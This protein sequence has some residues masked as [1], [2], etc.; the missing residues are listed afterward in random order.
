MLFFDSLGVGGAGGDGCKYVAHDERRKYKWSLV[1][2]FGISS[3]TPEGN[4][5]ASSSSR[6][7]NKSKQP[8]EKPSQAAIG[9]QV[10]S[11]E[12]PSEGSTAKPPMGPGSALPP[13]PAG[14]PSAANKKKKAT[15]L[16]HLA[17]DNTLWR[18]ALTED[19]SS[20]IIVRN[21]AT[22]IASSLHIV[23][24]HNEPWI[25]TIE[26]R[27]TFVYSPPDP[28]A[29]PDKPTFRVGAL[30]YLDWFNTPCEVKI[31]EESIPAV[32]KLSNGGHGG[33]G[34]RGG[35][36]GIGANGAN[37]GEIS[38]A[39][40]NP[41]LMLN[42]HAE[43]LGGNGGFPGVAGPGGKGGAGGKGQVVGM[44]GP[45][46]VSGPEAPPGVAGKR[47]N[48]TFIRLDANGK[49][50]Q[51]GPKKPELKL[52]SMEVKCMSGSALLET[53]ERALMTLKFT[54]IG[55]ISCPPK[56]LVAISN[57]TNLTCETGFLIDEWL[58]PKAEYTVRLNVTLGPAPG[59][60]S[61]DLTCSVLGG[62]LYRASHELKEL[63]H[64]VEI[65]TI[66]NSPHVVF[67]QE[68]ELGAIIQNS[69]GIAT[70]EIHGR[71]IRCEI[72]LE[73]GLSF[74]DGA[75][76]TSTMSPDGLSVVE[77]VEDMREAPERVIRRVKFS[78]ELPPFS[79]K[80][81]TFRLYWRDDK[82]GEVTGKVK[83]I[84][85]Y[86]AEAATDAD[87]LVITHP[88][89]SSK[90][91]ARL[92]AMFDEYKLRVVTWDYYYYK[93]MKLPN[94][95]RAKLMLFCLRDAADIELLATDQIR[96]HFYGDDGSDQD[97]SLLILS[98][99][100]SET[101][102]LLNRRLVEVG[103]DATDEEMTKKFFSKPTTK[104]FNEVVHGLEK[105]YFPTF[106][107]YFVWSTSKEAPTKVTSGVRSKW[108]LGEVKILRSTLTY[109]HRLYIMDCDWITADTIAAKESEIL[110]VAI[111]HSLPISHKIFLIETDQRQNSAAITE[112]ALYYDLKSEFF[113]LPRPLTFLKQ[114]TDLLFQFTYR[115]ATER[116]VEAVMRCLYRL[117]AATYWKS[118]GFSDFK[119][120]Y[121][122]LESIIKRLKETLSSFSFEL[123]TNAAV[124]AKGGRRLDF[125][126]IDQKAQ[127]G[128]KSSSRVKWRKQ[129]LP[130]RLREIPEKEDLKVAP[131]ADISDIGLPP[132]NFNPSFLDAT[133]ATLTA[134]NIQ[135]QPPI[136]TPSSGS[137]S[138]S[139][140]TAAV[141]RSA[142]IS[143]GGSPLSTS[144]SG[145]ASAG[146]TVASTGRMAQEPLPYPDLHPEEND[147]LSG[148]PFDEPA[149]PPLP[150]NT[151]NL[152]PPPTGSAAFPSSSGLGIT[153]DM[154]ADYPQ[155]LPPLP[156]SPGPQASAE[157]QA[158]PSYY[159]EPAQP[160][161][162]DP[163]Q[164]LQTQVPPSATYNEETM[165]EKMNRLNNLLNE[166]PPTDTAAL[167]P[168]PLPAP[169]TQ[170]QVGYMSPT[171]DNSSSAPQFRAEVET[172]GNP[173]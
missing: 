63:S 48:I 173:F 127:A 91:F 154:T 162:V 112:A 76:R 37:G 166:A 142:L 115:Y 83:M 147:G 165:E 41:A 130:L 75:T 21:G 28:A 78:P 1:G 85:P 106:P 25:V 137:S 51:S 71:P 164:H 131:P 110:S 74:A 119:S 43:S 22:S 170:A 79:S 121:T 123:E 36:A 107:D 101:I 146:A 124:H 65:C 117:K 40:T 31:V 44:T 120:K 68:F 60:A 103:H 93:G 87:A 20:F 132:P 152:P 5:P 94:F 80:S 122:V 24:W 52:N 148:S 23:D 9:V 90:A 56:T 163:A 57:A 167:L 32:Y 141:G 125:A 113:F 138:P 153:H 116:I 100:P 158:E 54:N 149:L 53:G 96:A 126:A 46:G 114:I 129:P 139:S 38:I 42:V 157:P 29:T 105:Q 67:G 86:D 109:F 98:P 111:R 27:N 35:A 70:G 144:S 2:G 150:A 89:F 11:E 95:F 168:P 172:P 159:Q 50:L 171:S 108:K 73:P 19:G 39:T 33:Q 161:Y 62:L 169:E 17:W 55:D 88:G 92:I 16:E 81:W 4:P 26:N 3:S 99:D 118:F 72:I 134:K 97:S 136:H 58:E 102:S 34:G 66:L 49:V 30:Q 135:S 151:Q 104:D 156:A 82:V 6:K 7:R 15:Y 61:F 143:S 160:Y 18:A 155:A 145:G 8:P 59:T 133:D 12:T 10:S 69:S 13:I 84:P 64:P 14:I 128:A 77:T 47:G 45:D 140:S